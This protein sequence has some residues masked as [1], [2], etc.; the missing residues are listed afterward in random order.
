MLIFYDYLHRRELGL[1][2][3]KSAEVCFAMKKVKGQVIELF[4]AVPLYT[5]KMKQ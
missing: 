5:V 1:R 4:E 2:D 3:E